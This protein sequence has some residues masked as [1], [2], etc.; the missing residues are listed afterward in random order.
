MLINFFFSKKP[1][2]FIRRISNLNFVHGTVVLTTN[3]YE[4]LTMKKREDYST[5]KKKTPLPKLK[6]RQGEN[7]RRT[8]V[9]I[10]NLQIQAQQVKYLLKIQWSLHHR[11]DIKIEIVIEPIRISHYGMLESILVILS[12]SKFDTRS[13][14]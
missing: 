1:V 11:E 2:L 13:S 5:S 7:E 14:F 9:E 10:A 8:R 3:I 12:Q 4:I 6:K